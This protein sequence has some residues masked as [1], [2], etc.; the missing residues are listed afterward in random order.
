[1]AARAGLVGVTPHALRHTCVAL[2]IGEG[3]NPLMMQRQLG[4][5]DLRMTLGTY[6]HLFP[7]WDGAVA[8]R[9][10]ALWLRTKAA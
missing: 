3:A 7:D 5:A 9:M 4:H 10:L 1:V 6:D 8:D 2:M